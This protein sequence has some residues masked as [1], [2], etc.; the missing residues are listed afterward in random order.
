M[1]E[2]R[3][4]ERNI[5]GTGRVLRDGEADPLIRELLIGSGVP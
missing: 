5:G 4:K 1:Y 3:K 2:G